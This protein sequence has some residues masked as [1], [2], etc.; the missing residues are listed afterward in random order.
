MPVL[1]PLPSAVLGG[2]TLFVVLMLIYAWYESSRRSAPAN[3]N[4]HGAAGAPGERRGGPRPRLAAPSSAG[5]S[6]VFVAVL[7]AFSALALALP[8]NRPIQLLPGLVVGAIAASAAAR[9]FARRRLDAFT[10][11]LPDALDLLSSSLRT[12][13]PIRAGLDLVAREMPD[14]LGEEFGAV[15]REIELGQGDVDAL[16]NLAARLDS[17][18]VQM[19]VTS[20]AVQKEVGGNLAEVLSTLAK[21]IRA[22]FRIQGQV[23]AYTAQ[24]RLSA[25][26]LVALP[27]VFAT[28]LYAI[29]PAYLGLLVTDPAGHAL[30]LAAL[31]GWLAGWLVIR[32]ILAVQV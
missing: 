8:P 2:V 22:R 19:L 32:R 6:A 15:V 9:W 3:G 4:G 12:G 31:L 5:Q 7:L 11:A 13:Q 18:D 16:E 30:L 28:I 24:A 10:A 20:I 23:E 14:P 27:L 26:V 21:T 17:L 1:P 29:R 25:V